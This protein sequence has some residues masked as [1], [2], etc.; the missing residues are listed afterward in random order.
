MIEK[1]S[2][3]TENGLDEAVLSTEGGHGKVEV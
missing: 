3:G 2:K 1:T